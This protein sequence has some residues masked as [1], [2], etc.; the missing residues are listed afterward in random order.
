MQLMT[1]EFRDVGQQEDKSAHSFSVS[2][3][4]ESLHYG[5]HDS[6]VKTCVCLS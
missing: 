1:L 3:L 2:A 6:V 4:K 5:G